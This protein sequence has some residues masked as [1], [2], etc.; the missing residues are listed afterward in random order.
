MDIILRL[1]AAF[2]RGLGRK[3]VIG[4]MPFKPKRFKDLHSIYQE[5]WLSSFIASSEQYSLAM[6]AS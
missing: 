4:G 6:T 3:L 5:L 2:F 1:L